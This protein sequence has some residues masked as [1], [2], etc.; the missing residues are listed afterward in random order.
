MNGQTRARLA[1][2]AVSVILLLTGIAGCESKPGAEQATEIANSSYRLTLNE[3]QRDALGKAFHNDA[4]Q[5]SLH[6]ENL[7]TA[8]LT[9]KLKRQPAKLAAKVVAAYRDRG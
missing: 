4:Q 1:A 5:A 2:V 9:R 8:E 3:N 6:T 7:V